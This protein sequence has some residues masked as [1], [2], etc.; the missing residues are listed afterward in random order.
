M[1]RLRDVLRPLRVPADV[2]VV[3]EE[4]FRDWADTPGTVIYEAA[5][6]GRVFDAVA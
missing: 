6:E 3:S 5:N 4:V 2:I 1:V